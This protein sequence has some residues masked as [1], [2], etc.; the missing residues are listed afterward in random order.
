MALRHEI[1]KPELPETETERCKEI[2]ARRE[3]QADRCKYMHTHAERQADRCEDIHTVHAER[4]ACRHMRRHAQACRE[5]GA[6][7]FRKADRR[8]KTQKS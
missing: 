7:I 1:I 2:H 3:R 5:I 6:K 8:R 4:Q